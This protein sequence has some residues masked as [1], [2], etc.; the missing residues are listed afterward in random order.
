MQTEKMAAGAVFPP[1]SWNTVAHGVITPV[2]GDG[3]RLLIVY[4]GKHCPLCKAYL[5][6]LNGMLDAFAHANISVMTLSAD[7]QEEAQT[8]VQECGWTFPVGYGL[9]V[10]QMRTL[11]LYVSDPRSPQETDHQF[12]EP[13]VFVINPHG[14]TQIIDISNAPFARPALPAL[15][16][17]LQFVI[18]KDY[19]IR[20]R[21]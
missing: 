12:A 8:E 1:L 16:K 13:G 14:E 9:T 19:P 7:P 18:S 3:W 15:L 10:P 20:G 21:A 11:G 4:R 2:Q 5:D 6:E 17:G